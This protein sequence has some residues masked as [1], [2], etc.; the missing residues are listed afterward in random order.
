MRVNWFQSSPGPKAQSYPFILCTL[1]ISKLFQS[2]PGPKAQSYPRLGVSAAKAKVPILSR[3]EG[4][5]LPVSLPGF[6]LYS[7]VP[8]LSRPEGPELQPDCAGGNYLHSS[9]PLQARRPRA[10]N[11]LFNPPSVFTVP[12][13]S[14][15]EGP[16]LQGGPHYQKDE[17][18]SSNPLQARRPRATPDFGG[19]R[20]KN[21]SV[22]ILSRPE[23]P[24]LQLLD[25]QVTVYPN[26]VPILSRPEGPELRNLLNALR[27]P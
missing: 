22:P 21:M 9:N 12:I 1:G 19:D 16:E 23:G 2:S 18:N 20:T 3:P 15:P 7:V 6:F 11:R 17:S 27:S 14:R 8:I 24:E 13:L 5:E 10:T 4:P 25:Q 26:M